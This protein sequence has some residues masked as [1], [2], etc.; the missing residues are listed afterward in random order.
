MKPGSVPVKMLGG[1]L[2]VLLAGCSVQSAADPATAGETPAKIV[3]SASAS[4]IS[5]DSSYE[6]AVDVLPS[7]Q[8]DIITKADGD[9]VQVRRNKGELVEEGDVIIQLD[10]VDMER[11]RSKAALSLQSAEEQLLKAKRDLADSRSELTGSLSKAEDGLANLRKEYNKLRNDYDNGLVTKHQLETFETQVKAMET[12]VDALKRKKATLEATNPV[13]ALELQVEA[14]R[15]AL[16][17]VE[18]MLEHYDIKAPAAGLLTDMPI[19][20]GM[21]VP[22]GFKIGTLQQQNTIKLRAELTS[23]MKRLVEGKTELVAIMPGRGEQRKAQVTYL[24]SA[25]NP[26]TKTHTLELTADNSDGAWAPGSRAKLLIA[27]GDEQQRLAV[28]AGS[29]LQDKGQSYLFVLNGS[30]AEK[31][32]V[33]VG[34]E[35]QGMVEVVSG[36][37]AGEPIIVVGHHSLK[38]GEIVA[39]EEKKP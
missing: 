6:Q 17:D 22:R 20:A 24:A 16:T 37:S 5:W 7:L 35:K 2:C 33:T 23:E 1:L 28:P 31:R 30:K 21:V 25:M 4:L 8:L 10:K 11:Q 13:S 26:V 19:E 38:D 39:A 15:I 18:T 27:E 36:L 3:R 34:R 9:V 12:D 14:S 29:L 32:V